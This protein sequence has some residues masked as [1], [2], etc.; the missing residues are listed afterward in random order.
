MSRDSGASLR[1]VPY[2]WGPMRLHAHRCTPSCA[3]IPHTWNRKQVP[4]PR[5][6]RGAQLYRHLW[7]ATPWGSVPPLQTESRSAASRA[8]CN[9]H[10]VAESSQPCRPGGGAYTGTWEGASAVPTLSLTFDCVVPGNRRPGCQ[11][12]PLISHAHQGP[13]GDSGLRFSCHQVTPVTER[14]SPDLA[15]LS[16]KTRPLPAGQAA[17]GLGQW[18][19]LH[20]QQVGVR[21]PHKP[22]RWAGLQTRTQVPNCSLLA[23]FPSGAKCAIQETAAQQKSGAC[24]IHQGP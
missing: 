16:L 12:A 2:F 3:P 9:T 21:A 18:D 23:S 10:S 1:N 14:Q 6:L 17:R 24:I 19:V 22:L 20:P 15:T 13:T 4:S 7:A 5:C 8:R 11:V